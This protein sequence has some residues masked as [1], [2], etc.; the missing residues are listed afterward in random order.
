MATEA[1]ARAILSELHT[2]ARVRAHLSQV[3]TRVC[4]GGWRIY[5]YH[6]TFKRALW[7][8]SQDEWQS[9]RAMWSACDA[10]EEG[11]TA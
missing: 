8:T 5:V 7:I 1:E 9:I 6:E 2:D 3:R 10:W 4:R 11:E